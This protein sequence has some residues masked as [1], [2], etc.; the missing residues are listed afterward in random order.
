MIVFQGHSV[1]KEDQKIHNNELNYRLLY[2][3]YIYNQ[4][5]EEFERNYEKTSIM[6]AI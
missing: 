5:I 1:L 6:F 2:R 3:W 4:N